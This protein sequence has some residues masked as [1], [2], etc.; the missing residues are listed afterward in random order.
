M[1]VTR[2]A[3]VS[4]EAVNE[5]LKCRLKTEVLFFIENCPELP[6]VLPLATSESCSPPLKS[7]T[8]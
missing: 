7:I 2:D 6:Q 5:V 1:L 4:E 8:S 3:V